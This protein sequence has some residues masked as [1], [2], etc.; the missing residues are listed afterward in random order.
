MGYIVEIAFNIKNNISYFETQNHLKEI[1]YE[2]NGNECYF[3]HEMEGKGKNI[4]SNMCVCI[5]IFDNYEY[6]ENNKVNKFEE[7]NNN[8]FDNDTDN[9]IDINSC[10]KF[11]ISLK[12]SKILKN[13]YVEDIYNSISF[14][15]I[16]ASNRF[17]SR[18]GKNTR[19]NYNLKRKNIIINEKERNLLTY[20]PRK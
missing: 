9:D 3:I 15:I 13:I 11:F 6:N 4:K 14:D 10:K 20:I 5:C 12:K 2:N 7:F 16:Y 18:M 1:F 17:L 8:E 19:K